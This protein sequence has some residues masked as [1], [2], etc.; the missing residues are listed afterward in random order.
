MVEFSWFHPLGDLKRLYQMLLLLD[1]SDH[2]HLAS[3]KNKV[4]HQEVKEVM[5]GPPEKALQYR[6]WCTGI[7]L[8]PQVSLLKLLD[9]HPLWFENHVAHIIMGPIMIEDPL[10]L[11]HSLPEWRSRKGCE[12]RE[13]RKFNMVL[14]NEVHR[15]FKN[16]WVVSIESATSSID[17]PTPVKIPSSMSI[18]S[19]LAICLTRIR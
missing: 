12:N 7:F 11:L 4:R 5:S 19:L 14:L 2:L 13:G 8:R 10:F 16:G 9:G 1:P 15:P 3:P 6:A 18:P 17:S